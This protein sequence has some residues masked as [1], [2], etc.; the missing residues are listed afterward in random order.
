[1]NKPVAVNP[2]VARCWTGRERGDVSS[3]QGRSFERHHVGQTCIVGD[4]DPEE[5]EQPIAIERVAQ[6]IRMVALPQQLSI[7]SRGSHEDTHGIR[8]DARQRSVRPQ[9]LLPAVL[10]QP[11]CRPKA[12]NDGVAVVTHVGRGAVKRGTVEARVDLVACPDQAHRIRP[13]IGPLRRRVW[14]ELAV[15]RAETALVD[16]GICR[17]DPETFGKQPVPQHRVAHQIVG[18]SG[19]R[20]VRRRSRVLPR[21]EEGLHVDELRM[22]AAGN[23]VVR[24]EVGGVG[25]V[26]QCEVAADSLVEP[27]QRLNAV[28]VALG[29]EFDPP[30]LDTIENLHRGE[31]GLE[32]LSVHP[33][34][35]L[36]E[37]QVDRL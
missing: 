36:A 3:R 20:R 15:R 4:L 8:L 11:V 34:Q 10:K 35:Q 28:A 27:R 31:R 1:M 32:P 33:S 14:P 9:Q 29:C 22:L 13:G 30:V 16:A 6:H 23:E 37:M 26:E 18:P 19:C 2:H 24:V 21:L 25:H 7:R 5:V 17:R 12:S